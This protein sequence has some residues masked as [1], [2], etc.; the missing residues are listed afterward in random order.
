MC[1]GADVTDI[2][3]L[4]GRLGGDLNKEFTTAAVLGFD[5]IELRIPEGDLD[6]H[7]VWSDVG[8]RNLRAL[9]ADHGVY[10]P[11]INGDHFK[12]GHLISTDPGDRRAGV[13][14]LQ[15]LLVSAGELGARR[16]LVPFF[17]ACELQSPDAV[18]LAVRSLTQCLPA[19][20]SAGVDLSVETTLTAEE[21]LALVAR[22]DHPRVKV[23]YDVGNAA[24]FGVDVAEE[25][26]LL[27]AM[28]SGVHL[29]DR[30]LS[31]PNVPMGRGAVDFNMVFSAL[32]ALPFRGPYILETTPGDSPVEHARRHLGFVRDHMKRASLAAGRRVNGGGN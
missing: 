21:V 22:V 2:G 6:R 8:R 29:K 20:E 13:A 26:E 30:E 27:G 15:R 3:I 12:L 24:A 1:S 18:D 11:S 32:L 14:A 16:V 17:D 9:T 25:L 5:C 7:P 4:Q 28:V 31:G 23:Y 19:A 10:T